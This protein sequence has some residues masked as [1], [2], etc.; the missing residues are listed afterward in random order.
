MVRR[1]GV[2][3]PEAT[4]DADAPL[5]DQLAAFLGRKV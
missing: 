4:C 3:G 2:F 5:E 1:E